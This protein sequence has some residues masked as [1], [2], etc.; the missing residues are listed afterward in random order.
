MKI[1]CG[2]C[3]LAQSARVEPDSL[4][5]PQSHRDREPGDSEAAGRRSVIEIHVATFAIELERT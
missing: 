4:T 5:Y 1:R 2:G 3:P